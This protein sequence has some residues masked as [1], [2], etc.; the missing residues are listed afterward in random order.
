M[1]KI[2]RICIIDD[3]PITVFGIRKMLNLVVACDNI[4][5]FVNGKLAFDAIKKTFEEEGK[6]PD[7]IFLD[8]NMP[9]MDGWQFLEAFIAL[10]IQ[11]E[12]RVNVVTSSIDPFDI[13]K[14]ENYKRK[15]K[16]TIS[17][18]NKPIRKEDIAKMTV[19]SVIHKNV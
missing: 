4:K 9:I 7:V 17:F 1:T 5:A 8:I 12:V 15:T 14:W 2:D 18:N 11:Q 6:V 10:P 19:E 13:Q 3:D 16:H